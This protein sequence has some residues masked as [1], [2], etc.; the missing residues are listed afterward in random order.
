MDGLRRSFSREEIRTVIKFQVLL[1]K[2]PPAIH[3]ELVEALAGYAPSIQTVRHWVNFFRGGDTAVAD[4]ARSGRPVV[5][6]TDEM[7]AKVKVVLDEDRRSTVEHVAEEVG[8][9]V[10]TAHSI[11]TEQ[12]EMRKLAAKWVPHLLSEEQRQVRVRV[13]RSHLQRLRREPGLLNRIVTGDET[14]CYSFDPLLKSQSAEWHTPN[15]PRP[16]KAIRSRA[17]LKLLHCVFFDFQGVLLNYSMPR[18]QT[19]NGDV[20]LDILRKLRRA[21]RDKRPAELLDDG[22]LLLH[23]NAGPHRCHDVVETVVSWGW[24][25]LEHP[26]Y[27]PDLAPCDFFLFPKMKMPLRGICF[28]DEEAINTA[29]SASLRELTDA[30]LGQAFEQLQ[31]R[32]SKCVHNDGWYVE[33]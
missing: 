6:K 30:G 5:Q 16:T 9:S 33:L 24:E 1:G 17:A 27:S 23:D 7:V 22:V 28:E 15:S 19:V 26:P 2:E 14:W 31:R 32:W 18:G 25:I 21:I 10:G 13:C 20:Y 12:L 3:Q 29:V 4:A 11:I 8:I